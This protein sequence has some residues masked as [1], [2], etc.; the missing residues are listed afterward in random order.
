MQSEICKSNPCLLEERGER[1]GS[2]LARI[3]S[4]IGNKVDEVVEREFSESAFVGVEVFDELGEERDIAGENQSPIGL[5]SELLFGLVKER[6]ENGEV[7]EAGGDDETLAFEANVD[8]EEARGG[9]GKGIR[10]RLEIGK[11]EEGAASQAKV[12]PAHQH[13]FETH[14]LT[15]LIYLLHRTR[16]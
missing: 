6:E 9:A 14:D 1:K 3:R 16:H 15:N 11:G 2:F 10:V 13:L 7:E 8:G 5:K 4:N 12:L